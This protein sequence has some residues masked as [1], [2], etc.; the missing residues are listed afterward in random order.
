MKECVF[1][2]PEML[3]YQCSKRMVSDKL[4]HFSTPF[5]FSLRCFYGN[6]TYVLKGSTK[7]FHLFIFLF[8]SFL[9]LGLGWE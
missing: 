2:G 6:T 4:L 1:T 8:L 9:G 3:R 5:I 7:L